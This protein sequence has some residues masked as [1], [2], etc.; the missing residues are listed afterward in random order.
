MEAILAIVGGLGSVAFAATAVYLALRWRSETATTGKLRV[1][2]ILAEEGRH[3]ALRLAEALKA[4]K[5]ALE[6]RNAR[7]GV[8][9]E[10]QRQAIASLNTELAALATPD[11]VGRAFDR[12]GVTPVEPRTSG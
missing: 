4:G 6:D 8:T 12:E 10:D 9:I 3:D 5:L 2:V 11:S 7:L 1:E